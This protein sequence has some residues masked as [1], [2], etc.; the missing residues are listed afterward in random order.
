MAIN[1]L[2]QKDKLRW[3]MEKHQT[4]NGTQEQIR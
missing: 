2:G 4:R 3:D 1:T